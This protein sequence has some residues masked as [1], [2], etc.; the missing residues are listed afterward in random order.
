MSDSSEGWI[1]TFKTPDGEELER[2]D[3]DKWR[4]GPQ[5]RD[6]PRGKWIRIECRAATRERLREAKREG[7]TF[8]QLFNR[9]IEMVGESD[10]E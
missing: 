10:G 2:S 7:E 3:W 6:D 9:L 5:T 4:N 1:P 8:D